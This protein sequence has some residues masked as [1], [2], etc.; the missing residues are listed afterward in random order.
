MGLLVCR[1]TVY[2]GCPRTA[3]PEKK[4]EY[5]GKCDNVYLK[6]RVLPQAIIEKRHPKLDQSCNRESGI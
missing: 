1:A 6:E 4:R 5:L 3:S 2:T